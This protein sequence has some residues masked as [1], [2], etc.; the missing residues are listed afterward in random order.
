ME[1]THFYVGCNKNVS[2][3]Q[4]KDAVFIREIIRHP[5]CVWYNMVTKRYDTAGE[6]TENRAAVF[7]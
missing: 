2:P 4:V 7:Y 3:L 5:V 6:S 1:N